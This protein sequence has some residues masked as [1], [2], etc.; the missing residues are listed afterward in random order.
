MRLFT[1][2]AVE[3]KEKNVL[4]AHGA[5]GKLSHDIVSELFLPFFENKF[6][7]GRSFWSIANNIKSKLTWIG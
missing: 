4:L 5:G 1:D 3:M 7:M 2:T 6:L